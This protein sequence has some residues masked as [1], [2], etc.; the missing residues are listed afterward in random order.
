MLKF[1]KG[2]FLVKTVENNFSDLPLCS[3]DVRKNSFFKPD[4][5]EAAGVIKGLSSYLCKCTAINTCRQAAMLAGLAV[6]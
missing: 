4:S 5:C 2:L 6:F 3:G 1:L